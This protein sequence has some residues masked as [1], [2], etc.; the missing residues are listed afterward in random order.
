MATNRPIIPRRLG[1][2]ILTGYF[3]ESATA[4]GAWCGGLT[5]AGNCLIDSPGDPSV[6]VEAVSTY[7][8]G[9]GGRAYPG[10]PNFI[11]V[12]SVIAMI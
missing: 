9:I 5:R 12:L 3:K 10:N 11:L 7:R 4:V 8:L 6:A 1:F 2:E